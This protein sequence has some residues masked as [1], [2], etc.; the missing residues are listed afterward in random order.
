MVVRIQS[1]RKKTAMA[2]EAHFTFPAVTSLDDW[3]TGC[4]QDV[5]HLSSLV[6][7]LR[8]PWLEAVCEMAE[9][10]D[11]G[12]C[13]EKQAARD[14]AL[15]EQQCVGC[16]GTA[17][18]GTKRCKEALDRRRDHPGRRESWPAANA[19]AYVWPCLSARSQRLS[20][21]VALSCKR[22]RKQ[23]NIFRAFRQSGTLQ[24]LCYKSLCTAR[25]LPLGR[26]DQFPL[27]LPERYRVCCLHLPA[28]LPT[29]LPTYP[30]LCVLP[31]TTRLSP[32]QTP[33]I[34]HHQHRLYTLDTI[35][36]PH[37]VPHSP[38]TPLPAALSPTKQ[39]H[40]VFAAVHVELSSA[41]A[42]APAFA[43]QQ[44]CRKKKELPADPPISAF[45]LRP[46]CLLR[47]LIPRRCRRR[48]PLCDR[49]CPVRPP[50]PTCA[51]KSYTNMAAAT[52]YQ[53]RRPAQLRG[54][55]PAASATPRRSSTRKSARGAT[56]DWYCCRPKPPLPYTRV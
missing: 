56:I 27:H 18:G 50:S 55:Q 25:C 7:T 29:Y 14:W 31:S 52:R 39:K 33:V 54:Q 8:R 12:G 24:C 2:W 26:S 53:K 15:S 48:S 36:P 38:I 5:C 40:A 30:H 41:P 35:S 1:V 32:H 4:F 19:S 6:R 17:I 3:R 16:P 46:A 51:P 13:G 11:S 22:Q 45:K 44:L 47:P 49:A 34:L 9:Q 43:A 37:P 42:P 10:A 20:T 28:C 21:T 23:S